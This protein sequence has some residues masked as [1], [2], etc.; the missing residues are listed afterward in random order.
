MRVDSMLNQNDLQ[1]TI[2]AYI[3]TSLMLNSNVLSAR[4]RRYFR[5]LNETLEEDL[6]SLNEEPSQ[7]AA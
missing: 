4:T 5:E 1:Q 2:R 7:K 6:A 3:S